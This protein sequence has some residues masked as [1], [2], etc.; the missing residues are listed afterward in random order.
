MPSDI[1]D[2]DIR[3]NGTALSHAARQDVRSVTVEEDVEALSMFT[4]ELYNWDDEALK[5]SWSD[6]SLFAVGNA[7]E[8]SLGYVD[9]L[10]KVMVAEITGLE[11]AFTADHP[12]MLTVRGYD[13]RHRL[14]RARKTRTFARAKDSAI[15]AMVA[16]EA[17]LR[18][19][20][21]D[22][23]TTHT[24][25]VQSNQTDLEFLQRRAQL[26]G[27]EVYVRDK[28]L[29]FQ[30][31]QS[32]G[33]AAVT[34]SVD[35]DITEFTPRLTTQGQVGAVSVRGWDIKAKQAVLGKAT[36][37]QL[38]AMGGKSNGPRTADR[39][40]G[41]AAVAQVRQP[42]QTKAE[43]DQIALG[44]VSELAMAYIQ[45][46]VL[47]DGRPDLRAGQVVEITGAGT[48]FSGPYYVTSARHAITADNKFETSLT[49][50]RNAA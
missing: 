41:K 7:V 18:A 6:S 13:Y 5:V 27:W 11:P 38:S 24:H 19:Q 14:A 50:R 17:G 39:A 1:A 29:Y 12:P 46:E 3:I 2:F 33:H 49:V 26:I 42:V 43:A 32:T 23:K 15:V 48:K 31:P 47:C 4:L 10:A 36:E 44:Q 40:F 8:I 21:T 20:V 28:V 22:T 30:P 37:G 35:G 34:L 25:V 45:G 16:R 9:D